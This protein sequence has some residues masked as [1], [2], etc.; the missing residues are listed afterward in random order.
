[1]V[2]ISE[3]I[4]KLA[5]ELRHSVANPRLEAEVLISFALKKDKLWLIT[6][7]DDEVSSK[8]LQYI[9]KLGDKRASG[10]PAAYITGKKEFMSLEFTVNENVLIPRPET[11]ELV[12][13]I[14]DLY[15][16]RDNINILDLC[17]G[18]GAIC[19][20]LAYY[21]KDSHC[22]GIDIDENAIETARHN[23]AK[24]S[25]DN[26]CSFLTGNVLEKINLN[27]K[28]DIVV[29][30]PP[31]IESEVIPTLEKNVRDFE[32][33]IALDGGDDGL[34]FYRAIVGNAELY[35]KNEGMLFFEI[36]YNQGEALK[37]IMSKKF[38]NIQIIKDLSGHDRIACGKL[39]YKR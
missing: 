19:C 28:Y 6:H 24:L 2:K 33:L 29:S 1:M 35:L 18:S 12:S 31:Y 34:V 7:R 25:V 22:T 32:P 16:S 21:I 11:E 3:A 20:S 13:Y 36:G 37:N 38:D 27:R 39:R 8:A 30:N 17:T 9:A 4:S 5:R 14:I 26:R 23:A 15:S 10:M